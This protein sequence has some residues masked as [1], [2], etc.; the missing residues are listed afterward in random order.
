MQIHEYFLTFS[1]VAIANVNFFTAFCLCSLFSVNE[2]LFFVCVLTT[3]HR[4]GVHG[5]QH[6]TA[7]SSQ[8][9]SKRGHGVKKDTRVLAESISLVKPGEKMIKNRLPISEF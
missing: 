8:S 5:T 2:L 9:C 3:H 7:G 4:G 1:L 6:V